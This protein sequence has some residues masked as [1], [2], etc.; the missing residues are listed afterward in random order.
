MRHQRRMNEYGPTWYESG[1]VEWTA[2]APLGV[3]RDVDVCVMGAGLAGLTAARELARRGWSVAV[4]EAQ[5][6]AWNASGRNCGFVLPGFATAEDRLIERVGAEH[7]RALWG[8]SEM[9]LNY[10][11]DAIRDEEMPGVD[12]APGWLTVSRFDRGDGAAEDADLLGTLGATV[13]AWPTERTRA[14]LRSP[15]YHQALYYPDAFHI[16]PLNYARGLAAAAERAGA[17][18][19]ENTAVVS[20]DTDGARKHVQTASARIRADHVVLAGNVHLGDVMR[21][22]SDTLVPIFAYTIVTEPLGAGLA[23][24][25]ASRA[26]VSDSGY[27]SNHYRIVDGD[28]LLWCSRISIGQRDPQSYVASLIHDIRRVYPQLRD[29]RAAFAWVGVLGRTIHHMPQVGEMSPQVW[30][31]SGFAG[32]GLNTTAMAG[33]LIAAAITERDDRWRLFAPFELV[34]AGG[35]AGR[36][37]AQAFYYSLRARDVAHDWMAQRAISTAARK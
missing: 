33:A 24:A 7:A 10:V 6:V 21:R 31:A 29:V 1:A 30:V 17:R 9:G 19:Y 3:D 34:W 5:Q 22:L 27:A 12:P 35:R 23:D 2:R 13:E 37:A 15:L 20:V 36:A 32:H 26:A 25:V 14:A 4:L 28:R 16:H 18:I 11:R 8:L